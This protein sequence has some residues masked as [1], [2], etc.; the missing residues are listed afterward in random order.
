MRRSVRD[1]RSSVGCVQGAEQSPAAYND[2]LVEVYGL[3]QGALHQ[4]WNVRSVEN[5]TK[6]LGQGG[7]VR[8][9]VQAPESNHSV[10]VLMD[11]EDWWQRVPA[12]RNDN[13]TKDG[14]LVRR[15]CSHRIRAL[16]SP[17][18]STGC[19]GGSSG[20]CLTMLGLWDSM[21]V[22][23]MCGGE[24]AV[25]VVEDRAWV[26]LSAAAVRSAVVLWLTS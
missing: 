12:G 21:H 9:H 11:G 1:G 24:V 17:T 15:C 7:G 10:Y 14:L 20:S 4:G 13:I 22:C 25:L 18:R 23:C 19:A 3:T 8:L 26:W 5:H 6:R 2:K 16:N